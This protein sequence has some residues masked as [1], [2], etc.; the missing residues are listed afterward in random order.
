[1]DCF[2]CKHQESDWGYTK[3]REGFFHFPHS[4]GS[5][6]M[7]IG[8]FAKVGLILGENCEKFTPKEET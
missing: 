8:V 1:M 3:C 4:T 2:K 6:I 7:V 5:P